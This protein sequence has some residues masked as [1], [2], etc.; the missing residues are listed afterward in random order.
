MQRKYPTEREIENAISASQT[1]FS[2]YKLAT[3][4][5]RIQHAERFLAEF[6]KRKEELALD[7]ANQIGRPLAHGRVEV[8]GTISR[9][10]H[11]IAIAKDC[12]ADATN[13]VCL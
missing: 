10:K 11:M 2:L 13:E 9:G 1:A 8:D 5:E 6:E 12:L 3:L 4:D 7:L